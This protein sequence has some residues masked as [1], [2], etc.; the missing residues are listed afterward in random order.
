MIKTLN[1][2]VPPNLN[3]CG[4]LLGQFLLKGVWRYFNI[5]QRVKQVIDFLK[6]QNNSIMENILNDE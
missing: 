3:D 4:L 2:Y 6:I 1:V 5:D